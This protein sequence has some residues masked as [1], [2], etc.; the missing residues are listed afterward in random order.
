M[1][2]V[3]IILLNYNSSSDCRKC[4]S[5]L[6]HQK[7]VKFE[8]IIVDNCSREEDRIEAEKLCQEIGCTYIQASENRGY[9]AGNNIGLRY[10]VQNGYEYAMIANPD[11]EFPNDNYLAEMV[12][13]MDEDENIAVCAS[14]IIAPDGYHQNPMR[15][16]SYFEELFWPVTILR[17]R[18]NKIWFLEDF[19]KSGVCEKV[20]GC[21][22]VIRLSFVKK[23]N[24]F[25]ENVFLYS[26][27]PILAK[28]VEINKYKMDYMSN[29]Q[30][31]HRHIKSEK[32]DP[33]KRMKMSMVSRW[34][35]L[36]HYSG[37][38]RLMLFLLKLSFGIKRWYIMQF[39]K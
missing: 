3:A 7:A 6:I 25:D 14:D 39:I 28:Q 27:E 8:I 11:M 21:C 26:E 5:F 24:Y 9:N 17:N 1:A 32:G 12:K 23:I 36:T 22:F 38:S 19:A 34:Y 18:K 4:V 10:V 2:K 15:E 13:K 30:A 20:S 16:C 31:V 35:Y 29:I 37:Y 33:K